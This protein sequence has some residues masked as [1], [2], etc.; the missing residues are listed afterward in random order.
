[1]QKIKLIT[2]ARVFFTYHSPLTPDLFIVFFSNG[3]YP[4]N[5]EISECYLFHYFLNQ[6][7]RI[8]KR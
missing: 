8:C 3:S 6:K 1:M 7:H 2:C 4:S 5:A